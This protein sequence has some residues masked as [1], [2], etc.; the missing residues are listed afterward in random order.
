MS[1]EAGK[2]ATTEAGKVVY[3]EGGEVLNNTYLSTFD[4]LLKSRHSPKT[5]SK[6]N[7]FLNMNM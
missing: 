2:D 5:G 4:I 3:R 7:Y 6:K 1:R